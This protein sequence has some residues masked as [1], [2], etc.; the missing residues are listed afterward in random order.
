MR[1]INRI[2][3]VLTFFMLSTNSLAGD[4]TID[5]ETFSCIRDLAKGKEIAHAQLQCLF[6]PKWFCVDLM[7][8]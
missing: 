4:L 6:P 2:G 5:D 3:M 1:L 7:K 8:R